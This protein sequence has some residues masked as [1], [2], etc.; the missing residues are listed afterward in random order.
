[1]QQ[2]ERA[3]G[4]AR[5]AVAQA[6]IGVDDAD[7]IELREMMPLGDELRA[8]DDVEVAF[9][10][11]VELLAQPFDRLHEIARQHQHARLRETAPRPPPPAVRR[12]ARPA[13]SESVGLAFRALRRRR[14]REAAMMA[15]ELAPEAMIDQPGIAIRTWQA[16]AAGAAKRQRRI[17]AAI[18]E[19]KAPARRVRARSSPLR[20]GAAR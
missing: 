17:A 4:G 18:E 15:D 19:K 10:D 11:V 7:E 1:M 16:E 13:R 2:L 8:D 20:R 12:R 6:E 9:G 14:H 3:L 5:V